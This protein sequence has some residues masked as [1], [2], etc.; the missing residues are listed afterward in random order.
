MQRQLRLLPPPPQPLAPRACETVP[1]PVGERELRLT[2]PVVE[3]RLSELLPA[4]IVPPPLVEAQELVPVL[5]FESGP[6]DR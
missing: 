4:S 2:P 5:R 1:R 6:A 3:P